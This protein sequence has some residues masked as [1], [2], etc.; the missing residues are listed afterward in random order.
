MRE[1]SADVAKDVK[2]CVVLNLGLFIVCLS[3]FKALLTSMC[4][5]LVFYS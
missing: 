5:G 3:R 1:S 4:S 2:T